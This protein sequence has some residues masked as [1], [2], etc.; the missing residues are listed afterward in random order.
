MIVLTKS[1]Q[2]ALIIIMVVLFA[3]ILIQWFRP[4]EINTKIYDYSLQDS[5]FKALSDDTIQA[6]IPNHVSPQ[7]KPLKSTV[8]KTEKK[9]ELKQKSIN[10]N[11]AGEKEL[12]KLPRIGP[13]TAKLIIEYRKTHGDFR[14]IEE[15]VNVKRIGPKT[16][17]QIAPYIFIKPDSTDSVDY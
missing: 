14:T 15:L 3:S 12:V 1:E 10:I 4:N 9:Q 2:R 17:D 5:L 7:N 6:E 16:L 11:T 8:V 13:A